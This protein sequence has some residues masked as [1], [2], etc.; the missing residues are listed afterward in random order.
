MF[1]ENLL[2]VLKGPILIPDIALDFESLI[3]KPLIQSFPGGV[4]IVVIHAISECRSE[5]SMAGQRKMF[6]D[7]LT[8]WASLPRWCKLIVNGRNDTVVRLIDKGIH[9]ER[10]E[11]VLN[12]GTGNGDDLMKLYQQI[13]QSSFP[14]R[15]GYTMSVFHHVMGAVIH[16]KVPLRE[17]DLPYFTSERKALVKSILSKVSTVL[18]IAADGQI[19]I[20][21][22]SLSNH[23]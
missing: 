1:A 14:K 12:G 19:R 6:I 18:S 7:S 2:P 8:A 15:D 13:L 10:L 3:K 5:G 21:H 16:S 23:L 9:E 11:Q 20:S 4:P 22:L 17:D